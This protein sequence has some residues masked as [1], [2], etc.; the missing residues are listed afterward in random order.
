MPTV[1]LV[2]VVEVGESERVSVTVMLLELPVMY[3]EYES[4]AVKRRDDRWPHSFSKY[5]WAKVLTPARY[6]GVNNGSEILRR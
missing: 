2:S 5:R 3:D 6:S 1:P 4:V